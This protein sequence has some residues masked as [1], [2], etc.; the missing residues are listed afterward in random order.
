MED[1]FFHFKTV[2][3]PRTANQNVEGREMAEASAVEVDS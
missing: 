1:Q 3:M 2:L